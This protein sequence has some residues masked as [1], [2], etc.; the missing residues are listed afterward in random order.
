[1]EGV[2][3]Q[4]KMLSKT[5]K[6]M[7]TDTQPLHLITFFEKIINEVKAWADRQLNVEIKLVSYRGTIENLFM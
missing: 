6:G 3:S 4:Q 1:M 2:Q 5:R 7:R